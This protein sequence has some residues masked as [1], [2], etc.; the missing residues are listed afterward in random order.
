MST[1]FPT[2]SGPLEGATLVQTEL[3]LCPDGF[4]MSADLKCLHSGRGVYV[5]GEH[6]FEDDPEMIVRA[7]LGQLKQMKELKE[8][9]KSRGEK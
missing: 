2:V 1:V 7:V 9:P 8:Q 5:E 3:V 6:C 4:N